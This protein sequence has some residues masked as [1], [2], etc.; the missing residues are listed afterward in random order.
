[1]ERENRT[2][3]LNRGE[4]ETSDR[5]MQMTKRAN[6]FLYLTSVFV[7]H[8]TEAEAKAFLD[9]VVSEYAAAKGISILSGESGAGGAGKGE[10]ET[11]TLSV[12]VLP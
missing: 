9:Q 8:T 4:R 12:E 3:V 5:K 7:A 11:E 2:T 10:K 6:L 1:M